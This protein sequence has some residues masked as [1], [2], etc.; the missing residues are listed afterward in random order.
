MDTHREKGFENLLVTS[1]ISNVLELHFPRGW[2]VFSRHL[3]DPTRHTFSLLKP[4]CK[5]V[6][7]LITVLGRGQ[8]LGPAAHQPLHHL[9]VALL[10]AAPSQAAVV[11]GS[12]WWWLWLWW[13]WWCPPLWCPP[14]RSWL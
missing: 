13:W 4:T 9:A 3:M 5:D 12:L 11:G 10:Q 2:V 14:R 7:T 6:M 1:K 8:A